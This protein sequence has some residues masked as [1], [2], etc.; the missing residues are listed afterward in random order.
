MIGGTIEMSGFSISTNEAEDFPFKGFGI[1]GFRLGIGPALRYNIPSRCEN[2]SI[3]L[4][5]VVSYNRCNLRAFDERYTYVDSD[6]DK[7]HYFYLTTY[8]GKGFDIPM[9]LSTELS[10]TITLNSFLALELSVGCDIT[11]SAK[12]QSLD[13]TI[14]LSAKWDDFETYYGSPTMNLLQQSKAGRILNNYTHIWF[15]ITIKMSGFGSESA[16][17]DWI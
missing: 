6:G 15:G 4:K 3:T 2:Q 16:N 10:Y 13:K 17:I 8:D 14:T 12:R 11:P 9:V 5:A 1:D 7:T